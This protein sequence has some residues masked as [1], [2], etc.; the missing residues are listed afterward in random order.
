MKVGVIG[1]G[2]V[3]LVTGACL[4]RVGHQVF[5][6]DNDTAKVERLKQGIMPI[7]EPG[8]EELVQQDVDS[9]LLSFTDSLATVVQHAE[10]LFITVGTPSR[11]DGSPDLSAVRAVARSVGQHLD[12]R[13]RVIVN[14]STVPVGS[15]NWVRMLVEDGARSP[16]AAA[17]GDGGV[18]VLQAP[19]ELHFDIV[20]N[21]EFL[22]E[23]SAVWD[24]FNP[25]RIV[26][27]AESERAEQVMRELYSYWVAPEEPD[28]TP[29]PLVVTDLASAEMIKYAANAFL[30]TK[31]SFINEIANICERVGADVS[32]VAQ[33]I[34][35]D[36]RIGN[37]F[38]NAGAGWGGSCFPKDVSALVSTGQEYG[39]ECSLLRATL[40]VNDTQRKRIIEKLQRELRILKGRTIAIWGL[41]FK[42]HTDDIRSAPALE[43]AT[44]LLNLGCRVVAHDPIVTAAQAQVQ[45]PDLQVTPSAL[46]ALEQADALVVMT[47]W[48]E[49]AQFDLAE[50][51]RLLRGR[52]VVDGR[53]CLKREAVQG[54][55][56]VY[57]GIGR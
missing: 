53:N 29:V 10:V 1:T 47:E 57:V 43:V 39:Y 26:I 9:G 48:P 8:L 31:I 21:P 30:A 12:S 51:S 6:M 25:D 56:L 20:S 15:G 45:V 19:P 5:C 49:Y 28:R 11:P 7:Y 18:A 24:T 46:A 40:A 52:V 34:G 2:Y 35:L 33:A 50:V 38:L 41:A 36:K 27:G 54:A 4:A 55:G 44:Q 22:R 3:G 13:Y 14:K 37:Q 17:A 42:P 16:V 32:R 23:G